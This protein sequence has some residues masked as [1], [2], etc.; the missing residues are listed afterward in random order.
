MSVWK[1]Q[2]GN[3]RLR[4]CALL[5]VCVKDSGGLLRPQVN[6]RHCLRQQVN[7]ALIFVQLSPQAV[8]ARSEIR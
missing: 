4:A 7:S 3:E 6:C 2:M 5:E 1:D 8:H